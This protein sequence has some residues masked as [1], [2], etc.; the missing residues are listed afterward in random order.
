[1]NELSDDILDSIFLC[2]KEIKDI[3]SFIGVN[4]RFN[5]RYKERINKYKLI[6]YVNQDYLNFYEILHKNNYT[7]D[8]NYIEKI[9]VKAFMNIPTIRYKVVDFYDLRYVFELMF[10]GYGLQSED[11]K[12][13]NIHFYIHFYDKIKK[14]LKFNREDTLNEIEKSSYLFTLKQSSNK[15]GKTWVSLIK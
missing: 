8:R 14:C 15:I 10:L 11:I 9:I 2:I 6:L 12:L 1:M 4:K 3:R 7:R 5:E 13:Y